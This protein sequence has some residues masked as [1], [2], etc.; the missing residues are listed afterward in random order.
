MTARTRHKQPS[1][2]KPRKRGFKKTKNLF[3][4]K[5]KEG[6]YEFAPLPSMDETLDM[7]SEKEKQ[8]TRTLGDE[9]LAKSVIHLQKEYP[10]GTLPEL[11]ALNYLRKWNVPYWYQVAMFGGH[12][13]GGLIPDFVVSNG[14]TGE[15]IEIQGTYWHE[16]FAHEEADRT[17]NIRMLGQIV[18]GVKIEK[19][20]EVWDTTLYKNP[21]EVMRLALAGIEMGR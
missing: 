21:D 7:R 19:V 10:N 16:G 3:G 13:K 9:K 2:K 20:I 18:N 17:S 4:S 11:V 1:F 5:P 12:R 8:V 14:G 6:T 15:A